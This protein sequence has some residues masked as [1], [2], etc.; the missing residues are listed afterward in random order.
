VSV[1][2]Q[3][4]H[5]QMLT[6]ILNVVVD[7]SAGRALCWDAIQPSRTG[8]CNKILGISGCRPLM[9]KELELHWQSVSLWK[10]QLTSQ[11]CLL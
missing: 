10:P 1:L 6:R 9:Q 4:A 11:V 7:T 8:L 2:N 3:D 5:L